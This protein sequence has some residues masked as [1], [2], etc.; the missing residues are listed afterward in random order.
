MPLLRYF[1]IA[2][3][4]LLALLFIVSAWL[5]A[6]AVRESNPG[7]LDKTTIRIG[8]NPSTFERVTIDTSVP[9]TQAPA[10]ASTD[11]ALPVVAEPI[12]TVQYPAREAFAKME[13]APAAAAAPSAPPKKVAARKH[14][15]RAVVAT[16]RPFGGLFALW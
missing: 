4:S 10:V 8:G 16:P 12:V 3:A 14:P 7:A 5:P 6:P 2:G 13:D 11:G 1:V 9:T 15:R